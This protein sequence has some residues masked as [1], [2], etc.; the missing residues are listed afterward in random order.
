MTTIRTGRFNGTS[1]QQWRSR[2]FE[3]MEEEGVLDTPS[4]EEFFATELARKPY[5]ATK[6]GFIFST[7]HGHGQE[8]PWNIP[9]D[10]TIEDETIYYSITIDQRECQR[11]YGEPYSPFL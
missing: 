8:Y 4:L 11:A 7:T 9:P 10:T 3:Y 2:Y 5:A 6:A 1:P